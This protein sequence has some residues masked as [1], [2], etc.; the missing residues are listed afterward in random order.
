MLQKIQNEFCLL[1]HQTQITYLID[2]T[3]HIKRKATKF[4]TLLDVVFFITL[5]KL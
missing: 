4:E 2:E 3:K 5:L 1:P